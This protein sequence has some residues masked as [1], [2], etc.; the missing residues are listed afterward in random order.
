M[1]HALIT[2]FLALF[3]LPAFSEDFPFGSI[4]L[5]ELQMKRYDKDTTA[6]AVVLNEFGTA[7]ISSGDRTPLVFEYHV[8]IKI[9]NTKGLEQGNIV[10][11]IYKSD[12]NTFEQVSDIKAVTFYLQNGGM[13]RAELDKKQIFQENKNRYWDLVKFAMP[14]LSEGCVIEYSYRLTS[15][16]KFNFKS[17]TFQWD[18]PK[19]RSEYIVKIPGVYNYNVSLKGFLKLSESPKMERIRECFTPGGGFKADCSKITYTM[20]NIPALVEEDYMTAPSNFRSAINFE[21]AEYTDFYGVKHKVTRDWK[22]IDLELKKH[23]SFGSQMK[24]KDV[25]KNVLPPVLSDITDELEKAKAVYSYVQNNYKWNNFRGVYCDDGIKKVFEKRTGSAADINLSLIAALAAAGIDAEAVLLSTRENGLVNK[26]FPVVSDFDYVAV[27]ANIGNESYLLDATDPLLPFGLLPLRCINDQ[28]RV[29]SLDKPSYWID[30]K[31]SEKESKVYN[32]HLTLNEEGKIQGKITSF[33]FGYE[34]LNRRKKIKSF[35]SVEEYV[36]NLDENMPKIKIIESDIQNLDRL[37]KAVV[38]EYEV[39]IDAYDNLNQQQFLF[40]PF[41]MDQQKENPF[42]LAERSFPVDWG[43]P[44][45]SKVI[46]TLNFPKQFE[47]A[48]PPGQQ[49]LSLPNNGGLYMTNLELNPGQLTFSQLLKLNKSIY[50][51]DEYPFLKELFNK[52]VQQH[53]TDIIFRKKS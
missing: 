20:T 45:E 53:K 30:L 33:F 32:L 44:S 49:G 19:I 22:D 13:Q 43:A 52:I 42:K 16:Y 11:P 24:K 51:S 31:A 4:T 9:L 34:A 8:K 17:W 18:I 28:G 12:N 5:E 47:V 1:K 26:L 39:E 48:S 6:S 3:I 38:E 29:I 10:I 27:K 2:F 23:D 14:N 40:N 25:F 21:L 36:E 15:P 41:F 37:D 35:N 46:M 7:S 50:L